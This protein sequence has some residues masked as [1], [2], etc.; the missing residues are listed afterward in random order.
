M[1][2]PDKHRWQDKQSAGGGEAA[3]A[4]DVFALAGDLA[5]RLIARDGQAVPLPEPAKVEAELDLSP[6]REGVSI[7]VVAERLWLLLECTPNTSGKRYFNQLFAGRDDAAMLGEMLAAV[8]NNS[9]YTFK[10]AGAQVLAER[11]LLAHMGRKV[12]WA[13]CDGAFTPGGSMS[14]FAAMLVARNVS[15]DGVREQGLDG[16]SVAIYTSAESHYSIRKNAGMLG[17]GRE[18]VRAIAADGEGRMQ[19]R[20][21]Q[22]TIER[23]LAEG[24]RPVAIVATAGTTVQGAFDPI[25]EIA[26]V[27]RE[28]GVWLH[29][30]GAFGGSLLLSERRRPLLDGCELADSFTWDAHKMMGV[31]LTCSVVLFRDSGL[32]QQSLDESASYLFQRDEDAHNPGVRSLQCGRRNDALKLWAAW[33]HHGD[34]GYER[35]V[36]RQFALT[37][38]AVGVI[39]RDPGLSLAHQPQSINV[40]FEISGV[41]A[42]EVCDLLDREGRLK[43]SHGSVDGRPTVRLVCANPDLTEADLDGFFEEIRRAAAIIGNR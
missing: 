8:A 17:L 13:S 32:L 27:A 19:V 28:H 5:R 31:P 10:A 1:T 29:V 3:G 42:R 18:C 11:A 14:N 2:Q 22:E 33:Q 34:A 41:D 12:G 20:V 30:D 24:V 25:R 35:R 21:L 40:C 16:R 23:D 4:G 38:H 43:V 9:M 26:G 7:E 39:E 36:E 15:L 37:A 6:P